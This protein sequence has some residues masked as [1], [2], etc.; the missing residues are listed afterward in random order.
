MVL[1][2][3]F[4]LFFFFFFCFVFLLLLFIYIYTRIYDRASRGLDSS[5]VVAPPPQTPLYS[6]WYLVPSTWYLVPS[7]WYLV[8]SARYL[9]PSTRHLVPSTWPQCLRSV[10]ESFL[11]EALPFFLLKLTERCLNT[12]GLRTLPRI[13]L[14]LGILP[15]VVAASVP[16]TLPSTRAGGQDDGSLTNSLKSPVGRVTF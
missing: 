14:I 6:T 7:T 15:E 10:L 1:F 8:P 5:W 4:F 2:L 12:G 11:G 9:A 3:L 16:Q 13:L